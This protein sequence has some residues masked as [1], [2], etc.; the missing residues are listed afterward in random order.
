MVTED[1]TAVAIVFERVNQRGVELDTVQLLSAWTWSGDFDLNHKFEE[2]AE[3]LQPFGFSG[4]GENKNLLLRCCAPSEYR[5]L[6][7]EDL[8]E[9]EKEQFLPDNTFSYYL[10]AFAKARGFCL[11]DRLVSCSPSRV[12]LDEKSTARQPS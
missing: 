9:I 10:L 6:M 7:P 1:K 3:Q 4:V 2:L 11:R 8:S 5:E 12:G